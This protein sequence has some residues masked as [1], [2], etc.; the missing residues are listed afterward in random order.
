LLASAE[1][2]RI[3]S[4]PRLLL[5]DRKGILRAELSSARDLEKTVAGL[6][7]DEPPSP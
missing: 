4:I 2:S 3:E 5:I 6:L 1:A 7:A